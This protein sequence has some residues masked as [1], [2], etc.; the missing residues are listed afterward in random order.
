MNNSFQ[1]FLQQKQKS[2]FS[3][4]KNWFVQTVLIEKLHNKF[5][6]TFLLAIT[7][8]IVAGIS[9]FGLLFAI[10]V[11][12]AVLTVPA[13]ISL[14]MYP[15]FGI[16]IYLSVSFCIMFLLR[17]GV[18]FPL[19]TLMDGMLALFVLGFF[20]Q[21]KKKT[22][23]KIFRSP[24][25]VWILIW[26]GYNILE[27]GNPAAESRMAW[28]YTIRGMALVTMMYFIFLYNIRTKK[29]IRFIF[30]WWLGFMIIAALY[31]FKQEYF[32]FFNFEEEYN[33]SE[34]VPSLLFIAGHWRKYS[35]FSDPVTFAYNMAIA[36]LL[37]IGLLTGPLKKVQR[38]ILITIIGLLLSGMLFSGTRGAFPLV[39]ASLLLYAILNYSKKIL[40]F[41]VVVA[42]FVSGLIFM[43]TSNQ[44][45]LRFQSAFRPNE[46]ASYNV[47]KINQARIKPYVWAHPLGGGLGS[48]GEWGKK[49][50]PGSFLAN[51]PPD[52]GYVRTTVEL[53][54]IGLVI[55]CI[56]IFIIIK[57]GIDHYY[58]IRDPELKSYC[59]AMV[60]MVFAWNI[61]N[62]PQEA[63]VQYPSNVIFYLTVALINVLYRVDQEQ[64][65][66]LH[67]E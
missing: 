22:D 48:T 41:V 36:S 17:V 7:I 50:S 39:P 19:G 43:P 51:F 62:F 66:H 37:C 13:I 1:I 25:S 12:A 2:K 31:A 45:I 9:K 4:L 28:I 32:G 42:V 58:K 67:Y 21:Q 55:F 47:R 60:L 65:K 54:W 10:L 57:T 49:F 16:I 27:F 18:K 35:V 59:L 33:H 30:K 23:W 14:V 52:S 61:A 64:Q 44:N 53:G 20:I 26:I 24:V 34:G 6:F 46:D 8:L 15:Q 56:M 11:I 40:L 63:L 38:I 3:L 29:F 5:G